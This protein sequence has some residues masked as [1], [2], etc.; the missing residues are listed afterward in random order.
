MLTGARS[1]SERLKFRLADTISRLQS[2]GRQDGVLL[3]EFQSFVGTAG[4]VWNSLSFD[5]CLGNGSQ[6]FAMG[7]AS[8]FSVPVD[9]Q[10]NLEVEPRIVLTF[11]S[12]GTAMNHEDAWTAERIRAAIKAIP[13]VGLACLPTPLQEAPR[14]SEALGSPANFRQ[15]GRPDRRCLRRQQDQESGVSPCCR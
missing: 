13:R 3:R 4:D 11:R 5:C 15:A 12:G 10:R 1:G 9:C 14:L 2:F 8:A 7:S 6:E